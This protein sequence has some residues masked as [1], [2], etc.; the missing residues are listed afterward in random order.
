MREIGPPRPYRHDMI[1]QRK[2]GI[3]KRSKITGR[4]GE[5]NAHWEMEGEERQNQSVKSLHDCQARI[6][7]VLGFVLI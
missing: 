2:D 6:P 1:R 5:N 3:G 7:D 4:G